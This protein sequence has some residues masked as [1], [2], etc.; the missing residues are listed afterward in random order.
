MRL[1]LKR[2]LVLRPLNSCKFL[3]APLLVG[4]EQFFHYSKNKTPSFNAATFSTNSENDPA[5][6]PQAHKIIDHS[7]SSLPHSSTLHLDPNSPKTDLENSQSDEVNPTTVPKRSFKEL[8]KIYGE[9]S[10][11]RLS[12]LVL[13]TAMFGYAMA[14]GPFVVSDFVIT[15][16]GTGLCTISA[17][18]W[19][20]IIE[21]EEDSLMKRTSDRVIPSGR[22]SKL[23]SIVFG[24]GTAVA[25]F[26]LLYNF[27]NPLAAYLAGGNILLYSLIYTPM[28]KV[29]PVNSWIGG[30]VGALPPLIGWAGCTGNLELG[31]WLLAALLFYWQLPHFMALS[32]MLQKDYIQ[33]GYNMLSR[34]HLAKVPQVAWRN[35]LYLLPLGVIAAAAN[36]TTWTFALD[37]LAV[38]AYLLYYAWIFRNEASTASARK[39]FTATLWYLPVVM[40]LMLIHK[41]A[42]F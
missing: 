26:A 14:T 32:Y 9:L 8:M 38:N 18:A 33:G 13:S 34:Y 10:K 31:G 17:A 28:K 21:A 7:S 3:C 36:I 2:K 37:S 5:T 19:N 40:S 41:A 4:R 1:V 11:F 12:L 42:W 20:Q 39:V 24:T 25:G 16:V 15:T 6:H 22:L 30:V 23:H 35:S 27:I 29:H